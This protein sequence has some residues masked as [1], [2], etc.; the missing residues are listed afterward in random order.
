MTTAAPPT[1]PVTP[2]RLHRLANTAQVAG[3]GPDGVMPDW[4]DEVAA[5][6]FVAAGNLQDRAAAARLN[7]DLALDALIGATR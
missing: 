1:E 7:R 6:L 3:W 5:A 2:A 4:L